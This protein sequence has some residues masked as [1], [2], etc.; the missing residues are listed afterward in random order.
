M[1]SPEQARTVF[2]AID[3]AYRRASIAA[4]ISEVPRFLLAQSFN[5]IVASLE[6]KNDEESPSLGAATADGREGTDSESSEEDD[7]DAA[8]E[9]DES[10]SS[11]DEAEAVAVGL[12]PAPATFAAADDSGE[13]E[14]EEDE[15]EEE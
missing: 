7:D 15:E 1:S 2:A 13:E 5:N 3:K 4:G 9:E 12:Q 11:E 8:E 14:E 6:L 10:E